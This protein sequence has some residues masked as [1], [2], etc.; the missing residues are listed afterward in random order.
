MSDDDICE[1][2]LELVRRLEARTRND[3]RAFAPSTPSE[4]DRVAAYCPPE[5]R[6]DYRGKSTGPEEPLSTVES[7]ENKGESTGS[8]SRYTQAEQS[9]M[10]NRAEIVPINTVRRSA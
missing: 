5:L 7:P 4:K 1:L 3:V 2:V 9:N 6:Y 8:P 10:D